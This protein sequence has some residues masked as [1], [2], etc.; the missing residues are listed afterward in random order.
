MAD[1][2]RSIVP[3]ENGPFYKVKFPDM[4]ESYFFQTIFP[5]YYTDV[6]TKIF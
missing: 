1:V 2:E 6:A 3:S 4:K 5:E